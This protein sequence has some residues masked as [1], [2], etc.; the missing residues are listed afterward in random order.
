MAGTSSGFSM[1]LVLKGLKQNIFLLENC[2]REGGIALPAVPAPP[3]LW[4]ALRD[5]FEDAITSLVACYEVTVITGRNTD[6]VTNNKLKWPINLFGTESTFWKFQGG[7]KLWVST[8]VVFVSMEVWFRP[9]IL[10]WP[11]FISIVAW[12]LGS[13]VGI[14]SW[15]SG[16]LMCGFTTIPIVGPARA[17]IK[18]VRLLIFTCAWCLK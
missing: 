8:S 14:I 9:I 12:S 7:V 3:S 11:A 18:S 1:Y 5:C 6:P 17:R 13:L 4:I 10:P 2:G 15:D 16:K